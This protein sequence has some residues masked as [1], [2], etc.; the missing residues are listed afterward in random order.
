VKSLAVGRYSVT[1]DEWDACIADGGCNG[2]RPADA[3]WGRGRRPVIS[4]SWDDAKTY[5]S[6]LS[7]KTGKIYRLPSEGERESV[8]RATVDM[9][10]VGLGR[11]KTKSDLVLLPSGRQIF[12]FLC[13]PHDRRAQNSGCG[14]TA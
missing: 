4:V 11:V 8:T 14:Y 10:A 6:W 7:R 2:Y 1:F 9:T 3:G 13:S 12:A 5:V